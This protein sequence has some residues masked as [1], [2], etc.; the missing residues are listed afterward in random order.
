MV[1][2]AQGPEVLSLGEAVREALDHNDRLVNQRDVVEQMDLGV[3]LANNNF[4]TKV[5]PNILGSFGQTDP[6]AR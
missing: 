5:T 4:R 2:L 1:V 6:V 3:Q